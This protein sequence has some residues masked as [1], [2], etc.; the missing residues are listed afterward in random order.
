M[1]LSVFQKE[2]VK[3]PAPA[4]IIEMVSMPSIEFKFKAG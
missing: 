3:L 4:F 2:Q 1:F